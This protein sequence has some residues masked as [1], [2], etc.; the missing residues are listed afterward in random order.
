MVGLGFHMRNRYAC[1]LCG[2]GRF[3][4]SI[5]ISGVLFFVFLG[6]AFLFLLFCDAL[7]T[8]LAPV[9]CSVASLKD[10]TPP[11]NLWNL[12]STQLSIFVGFFFFFFFFFFF[13]LSIVSFHSITPQ[14]SFCLPEWTTYF[15][16]PC[17][18]DAVVC[19]GPVSNS[20]SNSTCMPRTWLGLEDH[21]TV[22]RYEKSLQD[23]LG[24]KQ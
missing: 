12:P 8:S 3:L 20:P 9:T 7:N 2:V 15:R 13:R 18:P 11:L 17:R 6:S 4:H 5:V 22:S 14:L 10:H 21:A 1:A 16:E 19:F 24:Y 23:H